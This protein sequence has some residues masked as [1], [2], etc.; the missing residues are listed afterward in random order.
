MGSFAQR[1]GQLSRRSLESESAN[2]LRTTRANKLPNSLSLALDGTLREG[3]DMK[4]FGLGTVASMA[5]VPRY[6]RFT[7][8]MLEVYATMEGKLDAAASPSSSVW[9][10]H[11]PVLR[12]A[13]RLEAD[14]AAVGGARAT[15]PATARYVAAIEA[16]AARDDDDG[17]ARL[18]GRDA[19]VRGVS[20]RESDVMLYL[21]R[22]HE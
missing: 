10:E 13:R 1:L 18:L 21:V 7:A 12:R 17:G 3:H 9:R 20:S 2:I 11:G 4:A 22:V 6:A 19:G 15:S 8:S 16:A 5:S 14:L